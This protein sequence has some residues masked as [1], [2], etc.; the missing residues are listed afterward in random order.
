LKQLANI[1][2]LMTFGLGANADE[3][4]LMSDKDLKTLLVDRLNAFSET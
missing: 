3:A 4:E 1:P 2:A